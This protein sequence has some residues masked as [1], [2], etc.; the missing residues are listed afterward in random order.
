MS[1]K[2]SL[3]PIYDNFSSGDDYNSDSKYDGDSESEET[4]DSESDEDEKDDY[5]KKLESQ[6]QTLEAKLNQR[7]RARKTAG[8]LKAGTI[9]V[10]VAMA[11]LQRFHDVQVSQISYHSRNS[12]HS[13]GEP[14]RRM[15][16][17]LFLEFMKRLDAESTLLG[18][19]WRKATDRPHATPITFII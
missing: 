18:Y 2:A 3:V 6:V 4:T 17:R 13:P 14:A 15:M 10:R 11:T 1:Y 16:V 8:Q 5:T 7:A 9:T 12:R 19:Q